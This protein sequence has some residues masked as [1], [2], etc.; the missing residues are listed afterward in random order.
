MRDPANVT[1]NLT[2]LSD[3]G[4]KMKRE[5]RDSHRGAVSGRHFAFGAG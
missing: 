4:I 3:R 1:N 5:W 2:L